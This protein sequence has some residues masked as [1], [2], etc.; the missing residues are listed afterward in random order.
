MGRDR[1]KKLHPKLHRE[2]PAFLRVSVV[3]VEKWSFFLLL[4]PYS[5][6][7]IY[8]FSLSDFFSNDPII[9]LPPEKTPLLHSIDL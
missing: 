5:I 1:Q 3:K 7:S 6:S 8:F 2:I 9:A 4:S